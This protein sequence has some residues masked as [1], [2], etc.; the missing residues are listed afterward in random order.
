MVMF[1]FQP[2]IAIYCAGLNSLTDCAAAPEAA[3]A[4]NSLGLFNVTD[5]CQ[6][7]KAQICYI[8]SSYVF[9][10][11]DKNYQE[12]DIP[13]SI[14]MYGKNVASSEFYIQKTSLN[15]LIFRTCQLYGKGINPRQESFF[16][17]LQNRILI[18]KEVACDNSIKIG[19]LDIYYLGMLLKIAMDKEASNRL[20]QVTS[21]DIMTHYEFGKQYCEVFGAS[22]E[23]IVRGKWNFPLQES[24]SMSSNVAS[25]NIAYKMSTGNVEGFFNVTLPTIKES[26]EFTHRKLHGEKGSASREKSAGN[27]TYI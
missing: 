24:I 26:I 18:G 16:E 9:G 4:L 7:Y 8:S 14:T 20:F 11:D 17:Y 6:R 2:D 21:S 27:I 3:D 23:M 25:G 22:S 12:M 15:Y 13:D 19:F 10:G 1:S 5:Y